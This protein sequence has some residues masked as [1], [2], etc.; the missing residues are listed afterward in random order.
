MSL[1]HAILRLASLLTAPAHR[2]QWLEDWR[3]ELWYVREHRAT[4]CLGAFRDALW[5]RRTHPR[6]LLES[7]LACLAYFAA[8]ATACAALTLLLPAP[9]SLTATRHLRVDELPR[10][11][12]AMLLLTSLL[13]PAT[14]LAIGPAPTRANAFSWRRAAYFLTKVALVQPV[15][16]FGFFVMLWILPVLP[17]APHLAACGAWFLTFRWV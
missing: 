16:L 2:A 3:A 7:P 9:H 12:A 15:L 1:P 5:L 11:W 13:L 14:R 17:V 6:P 4:F 8:V 10:G